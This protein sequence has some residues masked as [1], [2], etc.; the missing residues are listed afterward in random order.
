MAQHQ[1]GVDP[2]W[3]KLEY[4]HLFFHDVGGWME[5]TVIPALQQTMP[6][7][8]RTYRS[9]FAQYGN[10]AT[11]GL[12][13]NLWLAEQESR[14]ERGQLALFAYGAAGAQAGALTF[15]Y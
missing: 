11:V 3:M 14:I 13:L 15:L 10:V 2:D 5:K 6:G 4:R 8:P 9:Y 12:P 7:L 1:L